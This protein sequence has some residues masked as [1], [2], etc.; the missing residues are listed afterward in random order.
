MEINF[1]LSRVM[2]RTLVNNVTPKTVSLPPAVVAR[3]LES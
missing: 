3:R 1:I 2:C